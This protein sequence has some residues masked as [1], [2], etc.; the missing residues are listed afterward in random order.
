MRFGAS[1]PYAMLESRNLI[2]DWDGTLFD[3]MYIKRS[4]FV[5]IAADFLE[6]RSSN[7]CRQILL[8]IFDENA[9]IKRREILERMYSEFDQVLD[10]H[11]YQELDAQLFRLNRL[12][13]RECCLFPDALRLINRL[14]KIGGNI[15]ISSSVP[16][17]ELDY[18]FA[19]AVPTSLKS[20][21]SGV[22]GSAK[23]FGKG[24]GHFSFIRSQSKTSIEEFL[25][26]GDDRSDVEIGRR[27]HVPSILIARRVNEVEN[28]FIPSINSL[29]LICTT[30]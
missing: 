17:L 14:Q 25:F 26:V 12:T 30:A 5:K 8:K 21:F 10:D 15:W 20:V 4:N 11:H 29:D 9:G 22:L 19:E 18:F 6:L 13:L 3:S 24:E 23:D 28:G 1:D 7:S 16:Q 27:S 2:F